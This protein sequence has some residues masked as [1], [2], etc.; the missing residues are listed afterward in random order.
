MNFLIVKCLEKVF[1]LTINN[2]HC[3]WHN[4][5]NLK[6]VPNAH[7]KA[8]T[9]SQWHNLLYIEHY[10]ATVR[11]F[12][13]IAWILSSCFIRSRSRKHLTGILRRY[14]KASAFPIWACVS[15][16]KYQRNPFYVLRLI[17]SANLDFP[18]DNLIETFSFY[19]NSVIKC[20]VKY[21]NMLSR[22]SAFIHH[23]HRLEWIV[24]NLC[25]IFSSH[26]KI[27]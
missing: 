8:F 6:R 19:H 25:E 24:E 26:I 3:I 2:R 15:V 9:H 14:F 23:H 22:K 18:P 1:Y 11:E 20:L 10:I 21:H 7:V 17:N 13:Y 16:T 4:G 12:R 5:N 27:L